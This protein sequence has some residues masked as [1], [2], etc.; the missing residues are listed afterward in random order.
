MTATVD[1]LMAV[2]T[3]GYHPVHPLLLLSV[4][5]V[6]T[7]SREVAMVMTA[8]DSTGFLGIEESGCRYLCPSCMSHKP[9]PDVKVA[10][11]DSTLHQFFAPTG[12]TSKVYEVDIN[13]VDVVLLAGYADLLRGHRWDFIKK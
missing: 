7:M 9:Y 13:H 3:T 11:S 12:Y 5:R 10:V 6:N 4:T 2:T 1:R 8:A